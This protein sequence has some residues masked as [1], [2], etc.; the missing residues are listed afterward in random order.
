MAER[1]DIDRASGAVH[2]RDL[3]RMIRTIVMVALIVILAAVA[4]DNRADVRVGYLLDEAL[5]PGW[6]VIVLSALGGLM[7]GWMMRLRS[8]GNHD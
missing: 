4:F 2:R 6:L 5:A 1:D 8:R 3:G 7:I